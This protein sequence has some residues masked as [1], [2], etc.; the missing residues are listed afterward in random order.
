MVKSIISN[1]IDFSIPAEVLSVDTIEETA[2]VDVKPLVD[3]LDG[4][5]N[6]VLTSGVIYG[7]PVVFMGGQDSLISIPVKVGDI[8]WLVPS[9][10]DL[11]NWV[12]SNGDANI[13]NTTKKFNINSCIA[14]TGL[15]TFTNNQ[16]PSK[17]NLEI[18]FND[19]N[20][21]LKPDGSF[22]LKNDN[23]SVTA[24]ANG[25]VE[26]DLPNSNMSFFADG[27]AVFNGGVFNIN[28]ATID[29]QGAIASPTSVSSPSIVANNVE[30]AGHDHNYVDHDP[31]T[32]TTKT[33]GPAK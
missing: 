28:G 6:H 12:R 32:A 1:Y 22:V 19:I 24:S 31:S 29:D 20:F 27:S 13:P 25:T 16:K 3:E 11:S 10:R 14:L 5:S 2:S 15:G 18:K 23:V 7:V 4:P 8:V 21:S 33:T 17:D 26:L 9:H 30:M